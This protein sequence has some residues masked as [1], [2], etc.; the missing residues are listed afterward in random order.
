MQPK[1]EKE[2]LQAL[3]RLH[4]R[5]MADAVLRNPQ[6]RDLLEDLT[7]TNASVER[8]KTPVKDPSGPM[9]GQTST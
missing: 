7:T 8:I 3:T 9:T 6:P 2:V 4:L 5:L 1:V